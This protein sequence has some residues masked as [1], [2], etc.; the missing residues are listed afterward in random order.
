MIVS[1]STE[2]DSFFYEIIGDGYDWAKQ[3][4]LI[5]DLNNTTLISVDGV[6]M[7]GIDTAHTDQNV[8]LRYERYL[9]GKSNVKKIPYIFSDSFDVNDSNSFYGFRNPVTEPFNMSELRDLSIRENNKTK[10]KMISVYQKGAD[11]K[12]YGRRKGNMQYLEDSW[13]IQIQPISYPYAYL[14]GGLLELTNPLEIKIRDNYVKLRVKYTGTQYAIVNALR[15][16][17]TISHA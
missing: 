17:F 5:M 10:E 16:L 1:N 8:K 2:P 6:S 14:A 9:I 12:Q 11:I 15:T 3:K 7:V 13:D 4:T